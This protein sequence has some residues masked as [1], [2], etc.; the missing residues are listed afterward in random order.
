LEKEPGNRIGSVNGI[1]EIKAHPWFADL[2]FEKLVNKQLEVPFKPKLSA[3][4]LDVSN[5]DN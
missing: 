3:D 5:F 2:S 4:M 1:E